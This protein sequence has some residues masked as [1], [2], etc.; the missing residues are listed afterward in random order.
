MDLPTCPACGQ[1]VIDDDAEDCPFCGASMSGKPSSGSTA[2]SKTKSPPTKKEKPKPTSKSEKQSSGSSSSSPTS[3]RKK[4]TESDDPFAVQ[5]PATGKVIALRPK[6]SPGRQFAVVCPMC[7]TTGYTSSK[8]SEQDVKCVNAKCL[9]P[10]F[11]A[12]KLG[13]VQEEEPQKEGSSALTL[14]I[15]VGLLLLVGGGLLYQFVLKPKNNPYNLDPIRPTVNNNNGKTDGPTDEN[16]PPNGNKEQQVNAN[17]TPHTENTEKW[18]TES[19]SLMQRESS[20]GK[21]YVTVSN[22]ARLTVEAAVAANHLQ[23]AQ[24]ALKGLKIA[25]QSYSYYQIL[26]LTSLAK[27]HRTTTG[28]TEPYLTEALSAIDSLREEQYTHDAV[29]HLA[30]LLVSEGKSET[31]EGLLSKWDNEAPRGQLSALLQQQRMVPSQDFS[32]LEQLQPIPHSDFPLRRCMTRLLVNQ[33]ESK[34]AL[35]WATASASD[36]Q[37]AD[38]LSAW[39]GQLFLET[40]VAADRSQV[41]E[42]IRTQLKSSSAMEKGMA[43]S[44]VA[45]SATVLNDQTNAA[46]AL[47]EGL[48]SLK[49]LPPPRPFTIPETVK[50][51]IGMRLPNQS[52]YRPAIR[53]A[54]GLARVQDLLGQQAEAMKTLKLGFNYIRSLSPTGSQIQQ[55]LNDSQDFRAVIE[56]DIAREF[57][58]T[59]D[60]KIRSKYQELRSTLLRLQSPAE[61]NH[62]LMAEVVIRT[63]DWSV[64]EQIWSELSQIIDRRPGITLKYDPDIDFRFHLRL[65]ENGKGSLVASIPSQYEEKQ[66]KTE[67]IERIRNIAFELL[68]AGK[69]AE[70]ALLLEGSK[71]NDISR[72]QQLSFEVLSKL[73]DEKKLSEAATFARRFR[74]V[75]W[76]EQ[77]ATQLAYQATRR[78]LGKEIHALARQLNLPPS[79]NV[80]LNYGFV[81]ALVDSKAQESTP[82]PQPSSK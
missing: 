13:V 58:L 18:I 25:S 29:I 39:A 3:A 17:G 31:A 10:I 27:V 15:V 41:L 44:E 54:F 57:S 30:A 65:K 34:K 48:K 66:F 20:K 74:D 5:K 21:D 22:S 16:D 47:D 60:D 69:F 53:V 52:Q 56:G 71:R 4:S 46:L 68:S 64:R 37:R 42:Q 12:P 19:L 49:Q 35:D 24:T 61:E 70:I 1:S 51:K 67:P 77:C 59:S 75:G 11:K 2:G 43:W 76:Q 6:A 80:A 55:L 40:T 38:C 63:A 28:S 78:G 26:P 8:A 72:R 36:F 32:H 81:L 9:V 50:E 73:I 82:E 7:E 33:G 79:V 14:G 62:Q 45:L 23:E